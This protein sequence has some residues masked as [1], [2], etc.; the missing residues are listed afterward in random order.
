MFKKRYNKYLKLKQYLKLFG[1]GSYIYFKLI[2]N[3]CQYFDRQM[4]TQLPLQ[5]LL[6]ARITKEAAA[7]KLKRLKS[8]IEI[9]GCT[10]IG[11]TPTFNR[12][13]IRIWQKN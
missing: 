5:C 9:I 12:A 11:H 10:E 7:S 6:Y 8:L 2:N 4:Y 1:V 3:V 13:I